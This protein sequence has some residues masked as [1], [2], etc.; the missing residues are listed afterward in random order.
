LEVSNPND[1]L[2][3]GQFVTARIQNGRSEERGMV[4]PLNALLR[5]ADGDWQVF[6]EHEPGE[7]EPKEVEIVRHMG[8]RV[9]IEG[10]ESG[11][12]VVTQGAFFVQS[13]LAKSGFAVHNH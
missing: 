9:Q 6:V 3:T 4:L 12:R 2:H 10:L 7:F 5:S 13:E 1:R 11:S 8:G